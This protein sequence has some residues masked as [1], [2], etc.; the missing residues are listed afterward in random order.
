METEF[1][2]FN[3]FKSIV[4][5]LLPKIVG[6]LAY[7]LFCWVLI[8]IVLFVIKKTLRF[9][10]IDVFIKKISKNEFL[11]GLKLNTDLSKI[12]LFFAKWFMIFILI[13]IGADIFGIERLSLE[14]N[15]II[16]FLPLL[17][18]AILI[19]FAGVYFASF[20]Q[21]AVKNTLNSFDIGGSKVLS[22]F[23]FYIIL[24]I[25]I[26]VSLNQLN[27]NTDIITSNLTVI[28][29]A[30]LAAVAIAVGLGSRD[31]I[32]RLLFGFYTRK[33]LKLGQTIKIN[34]KV[35][36]IIQIDNISMVLDCEGNKFVY[37]I[38]K[39]VDQV[40]EIVD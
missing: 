13:I 2:L 27:V 7:I 29:G 33:N 19:F 16:N 22:A 26:V 14:I 31:V 3:D 17:F 40:V 1:N 11:E 18:S 5:D 12:I 20:A 25:T 21:R 36:K 32:K 37:P 34:G 15:K 9:S 39:V 23:T 24:G 35:G 4:I 8:K 28:L 30:I 6:V 10:R 38:E